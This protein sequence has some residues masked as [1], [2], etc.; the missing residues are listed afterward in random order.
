MKL[1]LVVLVQI[2]EGYKSSDCTIMSRTP[3]DQQAFRISS[4]NQRGAYARCMRTRTRH[5]VPLSRF[6]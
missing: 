3:N 1:E 2:D 6:C 4:T 5:T